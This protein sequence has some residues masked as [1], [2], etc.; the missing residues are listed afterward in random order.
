MSS[1]RYLPR[2]RATGGKDCAHSAC[3]TSTDGH[4]PEDAIRPTRG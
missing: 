1:Q 3:T 2:Y 4:P